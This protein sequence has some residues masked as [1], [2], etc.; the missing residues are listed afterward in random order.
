MEEFTIEI[1]GISVG[2]RC[3]FQNNRTF[4]SDYMTQHE[5]LFWVE[6]SADD[7]IKAQ[8][9]FDKL[10]QIEGVPKS[11]RTD[12]FLENNAIHSLLAEGLVAHNVLLMHGS[13]LCIDDQGIV[14]T[15]S[16]G[17]GKSTQA[18][19]WREFFGDRVRMINDDKPMLR[20]TDSEVM[21]WGTPW[22]GKHH[23]SCNDKAPLKA[24]VS[25]KRGSNNWIEP[26][27]AVEAFTVLM[28]QC[29]ASQ[30]PP[31]MMRIMELEKQLLNTVKFY[32]LS[33]NISLEAAR[34]AWEG[35]SDSWCKTKE[36]QQWL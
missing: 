28:K 11:A 10:D 6:P 33:C 24:V 31:T 30:N 5:P 9:D 22:D 26:M 12:V 20:I 8:T 2:I 21:A 16:S 14:F 17:T 27:D 18:R 36:A 19:L 15:A 4:F 25:V 23:L 32:S 3:R 1:A 13:A 35:M 29:Y 34:V 7:L